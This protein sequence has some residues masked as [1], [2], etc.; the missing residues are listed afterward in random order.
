MHLQNALHQPKGSSICV[1]AVYQKMSGRTIP[2]GA[3]DCHNQ[4]YA[5]RT[6]PF[7]SLPSL[8]GVGQHQRADP[9]AGLAKHRVYV[10]STRQNDAQVMKTEAFSNTSLPSCS[11]VRLSC[12]SSESP[13][14]QALTCTRMPATPNIAQWQC[15]AQ[16][17]QAQTLSLHTSA[18]AF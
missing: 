9:M 11:L 12:R 6:S 2:E 8:P 7:S 18:G 3:Q 1:G 15:T 10:I 13:I 16:P 4:I 5:T 14:P 17:A